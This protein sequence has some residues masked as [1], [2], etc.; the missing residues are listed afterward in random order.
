MQNRKSLSTSKMSDVLHHHELEIDFLC[1]P[2]PDAAFSLHF[3][4]TCGNESHS[5]CR[6]FSMPSRYYGRS[7]LHFFLGLELVRGI[8]GL[9][10]VGSKWLLP[11]SK[12]K[13]EFAFGPDEVLL[14]FGNAVVLRHK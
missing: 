12:V 3:S 14:E 13:V 9:I 7:C 10:A 6:D 1:I 4:A 5:A 11:A 2:P 8:I